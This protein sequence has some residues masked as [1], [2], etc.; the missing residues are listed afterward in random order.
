MMNGA[1]SSPAFVQTST[2]T[3]SYSRAGTFTI[4]VVVRDNAGQSAKTSTTVKVGNGGGICTQEYAPVCGQPQYVCNAPLGAACTMQMPAPKTYSNRC[5]LNAAGATFLYSGVCANPYA[6]SCVND[7]ASY[8]E[9]TR[10]TCITTNGGSSCISDAGYV[11]RSGVWKIEGSMQTACPA[12]AM[13]CS[14]GSWVGRS[15]SSCQFICPVSS[16]SASSG[17][18]NS[19]CAAGYKWCGVGISGNSCVYAPTG[20]CPNVL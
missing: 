5:E 17:T 12:D 15:G 18:A 10:R 16:V 13:Q 11:C 9:G 4:T 1:A 8:P 19:Q 7:G 14:D 2:F 6:T 3:H 20:V